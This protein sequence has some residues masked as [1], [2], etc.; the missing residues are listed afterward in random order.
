VVFNQK[1]WITRERRSIKRGVDMKRLYYVRVLAAVVLFVL[2]ASVVSAEGRDPRAFRLTLNSLTAHRADVATLTYDRNS[3][4]LIPSDTFIKI[5]ATQGDVVFLE[6]FQG[7]GFTVGW[8][9]WSL[10]HRPAFTVRNCI[11]Y[12]S[13]VGRDIPLVLQQGNSRTTIKVVNGTTAQTLSR[14]GGWTKF[15]VANGRTIDILVL[16][17][18]SSSATLIIDPG[19]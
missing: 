17:V 12:G 15:Y 19:W 11:Y 16:G 14:Q 1:K 8:W 13:P 18:S 4:V 6:D 3:Q 9:G 2:S 7:N 5:V 10:P